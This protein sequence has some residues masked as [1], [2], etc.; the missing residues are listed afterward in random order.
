LNV[1]ILVLQGARDCQ[2]R[3]A[4]FDGWKKALAGHARVSFRLYP[5]LYHLF[6]PVPASDT[7]PLSTPEDYEQ[8]G[9]VALEVIADIAKC[10]QSQAGS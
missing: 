8:P 3:M 7:T 5:N 4:D 6:I 10:I 9:H 1:P 2:V